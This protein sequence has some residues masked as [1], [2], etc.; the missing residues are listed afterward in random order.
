M[1]R[2]T[3]IALVLLALVGGCARSSAVLRWERDRTA[4]DELVAHRYELAG[5]RRRQRLEAALARY[6]ALIARAPDRERKNQVLFAYGETLVRL[7]RRSEAIA[8]YRSIQR[9]TRDDEVRAKARY[10]IAQIALGQPSTRADGERQMDALILALPNTTFG[11]LALHHRIRRLRFEKRPLNQRLAYLMTM[12]DKLKPQRLSGRVLYWA[13]RFCQA[14][15]KRQRDAE[16]YYRKLIENHTIHP[17]RKAAIFRLGKMLFDQHRDREA[18]AT[19]LELWGLREVAFLFGSYE[20]VYYPEALFLVGEI[21][22]RRLKNYRRAIAWYQKLR[23]TYR[24]HALRD[25]SLYRIIECQ[26]ALGEREAAIESFR[27][28]RREGIDYIRVSTRDKRTGLQKVFKWESPFLKR[29][30]TLLERAGIRVR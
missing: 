16:T 9:A 18:I 1:R 11:D 13:A 7:T 27:L 14:D 21:Y 3:P 22:Q 12:Y 2:L 6:R 23:S 20:N 5:A 8:W 4:A 17:L 10:R 28:L 30:E 24:V 29:A 19:F 15:P 26:V 25:D